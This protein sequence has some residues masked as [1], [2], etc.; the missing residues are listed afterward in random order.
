[1]KTHIFEEC[2]MIDDKIYFKCKYCHIVYHALISKYDEAIDI[3]KK[4]PE[5]MSRCESG[6]NNDP[7]YY[8]FNNGRGVYNCLCKNHKAIKKFIIKKYNEILL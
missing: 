5:S 2:E 8:D 1:M 4:L 7:I 3:L 6:I